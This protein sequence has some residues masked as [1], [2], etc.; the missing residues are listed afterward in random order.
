V[1]EIE[2][3]THIQTASLYAFFT[4]TP[5]GFRGVKL[6]CSSGYGFV[7]F[8]GASQALAAMEAMQDQPLAAYAS[9]LKLKWGSAPPKRRRCRRHAGPRSLGRCQSALSLSGDLAY[10][11]TDEDLRC[12]V[13]RPAFASLTAIDIMR[14]VATGNSKGF[15]FVR[16]SA[17]DDARAAIALMN[18]AL[19]AGRPIRTSE[20]SQ[21]G[22]MRPVTSHNAMAPSSSR[23]GT[24][25]YGDRSRGSGQSGL[26]DPAPLTAGP[27]TGDFGGGM[28]VSP[29]GFVPRSRFGED[30]LCCVCL[31]AF[32]Y[33]SSLM[34]AARRATVARSQP[35]QQAMDV[36]HFLIV[37]RCSDNTSSTCSRNISRATNMPMVCAAPPQQQHHAFAPPPMPEEGQTTLFVGGLDAIVS[38]SRAL[39]SRSTHSGPS[40]A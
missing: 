32:V 4:P 24:V 16:F 28:S 40:L 3:T 7:D 1:F 25:S 17:D 31:D 30:M 12:S 10:E 19:I 18:G 9:T 33:A 29:D 36:A 23:T 20:A 8:E 14:D 27:W 35:L 37:C 11:A 6:F 21:R 15:A 26:Y 22:S 5:D 39:H 2:Q 13:C 38:R 34:Q